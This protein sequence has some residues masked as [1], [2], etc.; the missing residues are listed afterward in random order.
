MGED[1][2][3]GIFVPRGRPVPA[4]AQ[5]QGPGWVRT[6]AYFIPRGREVPAHLRGGDWVRVPVR[7][8]SRRPW[9]AAGGRPWPADGNGRVLPADRSGRPIGPVWAYPPGARAPGEVPPPGLPGLESGAA[10]LA[11]SRALFGDPVG[12]LRRYCGHD[13]LSRPNTG[14][15]EIGERNAAA[16]ATSPS[17]ALRTPLR[18]P[19]MPPRQA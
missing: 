10:A 5:A 3:P 18:P 19:A 15:E 16:P 6:P 11:A 1:E 9:Q 17:E 13:S 7:F 2:I 4:Q 14:M 12:W 8:V